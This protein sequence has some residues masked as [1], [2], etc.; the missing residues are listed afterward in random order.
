MIKIRN[1]MLLYEIL[2]IYESYLAE[3]AVVIFS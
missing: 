2:L 3:S 1:K